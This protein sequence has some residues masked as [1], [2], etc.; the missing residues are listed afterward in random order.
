[1]FQQEKT[2]T[3]DVETNHDLY[4]VK[5]E[6]YLIPHTRQKAIYKWI[7]DLNMKAKFDIL[8]NKDIF[9]VLEKKK[10]SETEKKVI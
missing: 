4:S 9:L 2:L 8:K 5:M 1:M 3:G 7:K 6:F 10:I